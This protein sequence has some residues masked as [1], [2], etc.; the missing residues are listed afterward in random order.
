MN[1]VGRHLSPGATSMLRRGSIGAEKLTISPD[2][3]GGLAAVFPDGLRPGAAVFIGGAVGAGISRFC[4]ELLAWWSVS[5]G[6]CVLVDL[7]GRASPAAIASSG[8]D[9][10]RLVVVRPPRR[11][12]DRLASA[13]GA[14]IDGFSLTAVIS[15]PGDIDEW[16]VRKALARAS[17]RRTLALFATLGGQLGTKPTSIDIA[18][19]CK[20]WSRDPFGVLK[21]RYIEARVRE[22]GIPREVL[23]VESATTP[24]LL[25]AA[26]E[27]GSLFVSTHGLRGV[28]AHDAYA[29]HEY[30]E[31][32][33]SGA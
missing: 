13:L 24:R 12:L 17:A 21:E 26:S 7:T 33:L 27:K 15:A 3:F 5:C 22:H 2:R 6:F 28:S 23:L 8:A 19:R 29:P 11:R 25:A 1:S 16:V 10:Y 14:L 4:Y 32:S 30:S 9:L 18:L 31:V 20:G